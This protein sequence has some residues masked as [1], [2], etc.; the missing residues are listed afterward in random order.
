MGPYFEV[1]GAGYGV[2]IPIPSLVVKIA[3]LKKDCKS[4]PGNALHAI[5]T[6]CNFLRSV[7]HF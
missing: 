4:K 6:S 1:L 7:T 5:S 2:R 3:S